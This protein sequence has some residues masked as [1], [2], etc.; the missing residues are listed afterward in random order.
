MASWIIWAYSGQTL[1]RAWCWTLLSCSVESPAACRV[2]NQLCAVSVP[3][4]ARIALHSA[5]AD[6]GPVSSEPPEKIATGT[7]IRAATMTSPP[8]A[9]MILPLRESP[10]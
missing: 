5:C 8:P 9:R 2:A 1:S 10:D 4:V 3:G 7:A 6:P